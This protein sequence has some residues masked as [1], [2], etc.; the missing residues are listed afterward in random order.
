MPLLLA[1]LSGVLLALSLPP[2]DLEWLAWIALVPLLTATK[3]RRPLENTGLGLAAGVA[4]GAVQV[5][6][7]E[8]TEGLRYAYL[9]FFL[10]AFLQALVAV[11]GGFARKRRQGLA[12]VAFV[13]CAGIAVEWLSTFSPLPLHLALSQYRAHTLIQIASLT[14]IWGVSFLLWWTN[15]AL[16]DALLER[17]PR[18]AALGAAC[19]AILLAYGCGALALSG[20]AD[21]GAAR[22]RAAA[23]QDYTPLD[24]GDFASTRSELGDASEGPD[25][26]ALTREAA[27]QGARLIVW[28]ELGLGVSFQPE[29]ADDPT[30]CLARELGAHLVAGYSEPGTP[31]GR[32]CAAIIA[33]D[34]SVRG[35]HRKVHL[36]LGERRDT[37]PGH[38]ARAFDTGLGRLGIEICFDTC[39]TGLTRRIAADG[40][41]LIA[42]PNFDPPTPGAVLHR[43]HGCILPFRAVE[44]AVPIVRADPSGYSQLIDRTGRIVRQ[45]P[46]WAPDALVGDLALGVGRAT[47]FTRLGDWVVYLCL[48]VLVGTCYKG[49]SPHTRGPSHGPPDRRA[50]GAD[51]PA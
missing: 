27:R 26:E 32:N 47:L 31:K 29:R 45:S 28:S 25:R 49:K 41:R 4:C 36:F 48:A 7:H 15:A 16:A 18:T 20:A 39:Y 23:I 50:K 43:L 19:A 42:M 21:P 46:M 3:D 51:Q 6:W 30:R 12:W 2:F 10:L 33:P 14:G 11:A 9:P 35:I 24:G 37:L 38:E 8:N 17:R 13:A 1:V 44:N 22:V 5:G 40:A 34:G